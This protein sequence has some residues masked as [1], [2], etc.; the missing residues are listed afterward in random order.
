MLKA[1]FHTALL[2][3]VLAGSLTAGDD[4]FIG[5]WK[6]NPAKGKTS[7]QHWKIESL[8]GNR[9]AF[10]SEIPYQIVADG[11]DQPTETGGTHSLKI[12]DPGTWRFVDK[13]DGAITL[14]DTLTL[15]PDGKTL[16]SH[17]ISTDASGSKHESSSH[18]KRVSGSGGFAGDW[19]STGFQM[20]PA[21][22]EFQPLAGGISFV[23]AAYK[24]HI[25]LK[26]DGN[27]Y[28]WQGPRTDPS[29]TS[30]AK[31]PKP[32]L[33]EILDK[34]NGKVV[35]TVEFRVSSDGKTLT[36][37]SK[38]ALQTTPEIVVFEKQ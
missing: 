32:D 7:G 24:R 8:G 4:P 29:M 14:E 25:D 13:R 33:L 28:A 35:D 34:H 12:I 36:L 26:F 3:V 6:S 30:S 5:K 9:Y 1:N 15:S 11:S 2:A 22:V 38:G 31:R 18:W 10:S 21:E 20:A 37:S 16:S 17:S 27:D 23:Y 19:E